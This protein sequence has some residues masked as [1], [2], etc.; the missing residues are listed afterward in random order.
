M[1]KQDVYEL[2]ED[3]HLANKLVDELT[4]QVDLEISDSEAKV[5]TVQ[6]I[7]VSDEGQAS[8]DS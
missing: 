4:G 6:E 1:D 3:Y 5:I 2:Y 8:A 7:S